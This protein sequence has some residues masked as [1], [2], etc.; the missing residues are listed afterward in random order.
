M[1]FKDA[2]SNLTSKGTGRQHI[3]RKI[4]YE[5]KK[6]GK[7]PLYFEV[8][9][10]AS[11]NNDELGVISAIFFEEMKSDRFRDVIHS[12]YIRKP[13]GE[14]FIWKELWKDRVVEFDVDLD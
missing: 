2:V 1:N 5:N 3:L 9:K 12:V 10:R 6:Q 8:G 11:Y 7:D 4:T 14:E 13:N